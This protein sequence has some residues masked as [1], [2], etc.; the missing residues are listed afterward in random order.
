MERLQFGGTET[1]IVVGAQGS[2]EIRGAKAGFGVVESLGD[3][4][5]D[6]GDEC[7]TISLGEMS[8]IQV[9]AGGRL[10]LGEV[11][12]PLRLQAVKRDVTVGTVNGSLQARD[13]GGDIEVSGPVSGNLR[14]QGA[15]NLSA[16]GAAPLRGDVKL[17]RLAQVNLAQVNG[18]L[19][20]RQVSGTVRLG[21][22]N[23]HSRVAN[24]TGGLVA[25]SIEGNLLLEGRFTGDSVWQ[26]Q[27]EGRTRL[28]MHPESSVRLELESENHPPSLDEEFQVVERSH[29]RAVATLGSGQAL[30]AIRAEGPVAAKVGASADAPDEFADAFADV[31][32]CGRACHG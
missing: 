10:Q 4:D 3:V 6:R 9:P 2:L 19:T 32:V 17:S 25:G 21:E 27:V 1:I 8:A 20:V 26:A 31:G 23:G 15:R 30:I 28:R 12:G 29:G 11:R 5:I 16:D 14:I 22:V 18:N 13:M 24:L 7:T